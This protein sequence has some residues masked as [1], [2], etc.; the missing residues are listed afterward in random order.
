MTDYTRAALDDLSRGAA[1]DRNLLRRRIEE[2]GWTTER[3]L[4][5]PPPPTYDRAAQ[6]AASR[7]SQKMLRWSRRDAGLCE[8]CD[9]PT[10]ERLCNLHREKERA[11]AQRYEAKRPKR[12]R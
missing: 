10:T 11:K 2:Y 3:A 7:A 8:R 5:E 9:T 6:L 12:E 4:T 1:V